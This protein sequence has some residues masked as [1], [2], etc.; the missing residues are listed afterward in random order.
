M[1]PLPNVRSWVLDRLESMQ[2]AQGPSSAWSTAKRFRDSGRW[3]LAE[4]TFELRKRAGSAA[5]GAE[6]PCV[7]CAMFERAK[8]LHELH[9]DADALLLL[10]AGAVHR[11]A[12]GDY[13]QPSL[14]EIEEF[15]LRLKDP[16]LAPSDQR[17][18]RL[19]LG[20]AL[21]PWISDHHR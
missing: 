15:R 19:D 5:N 7:P 18:L 2:R 3:A 20:H 4:D 17:E 11:R 14:R 13:Q 6:Y 12:F 8:C 1:N 21:W 10:D 9:R 16:R